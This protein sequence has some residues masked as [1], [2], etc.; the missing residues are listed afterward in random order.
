[1][2]NGES[3]ISTNLPSRVPALFD[4]VAELPREFSGKVTTS[5]THSPIQRTLTLKVEPSAALSPERRVVFPKIPGWNPPQFT[6][7][8]EAVKGTETLDAFS[9]PLSGGKAFE[10]KVVWQASWAGPGLE[11]LEKWRFFDQANQPAFEIV[12]P[13]DLSPLERRLRDYFLFCG[14]VI[15]G[16]P[17]VKPVA[18]VSPD[19]AT[20][21]RAK[22]VL[23]R[24]TEG[25]GQVSVPSAHEIRITYTTPEEAG[26]ALD[27]FFE[28]L[29]QRFRYEPGFVNTWGIGADMLEHYRMNGK[30][31]Q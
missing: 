1:V 29:D 13:S 10:V 27:H 23:E 30:T 20:A 6:V 19:Q 18:L 31:I 22:I 16:N 8:G 2:K 21:G 12:L 24:T 17:E 9:L 7:K 5:Y 15:L 4:A 14:R 25:P 28:R 11:H 26:R 3:V